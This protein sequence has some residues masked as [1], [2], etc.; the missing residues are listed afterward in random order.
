MT[1][2]SAAADGPPVPRLHRLIAAGHLRYWIIAAWALS[3]A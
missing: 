1:S 3:P 2:I